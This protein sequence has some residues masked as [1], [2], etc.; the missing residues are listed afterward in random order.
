[1]SELD[2]PDLLTQLKVCEATTPRKHRYNGSHR[3]R[4]V[5]NTIDWETVSQKIK[6]SEKKQPKQS[7]FQKMSSSF[8]SAERRS[9][10]QEEGFLMFEEGDG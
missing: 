5:R 3:P 9:F 4:S 2:N 6:E 1:M 7:F 10:T 8:A